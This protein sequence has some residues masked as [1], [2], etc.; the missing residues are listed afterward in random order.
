MDPSIIQPRMPEEA[1]VPGV[2]ASLGDLIRLQYKASGFSFLP[3]Q[4]VH[5]ILAGRRASR[6]RGR[7][8]DFEELRR[9]LPGDDIRSIDWKVTARTQK[10]YTRVF[11]EERDRPALLLVDQRIAMFYGTVRSLK[12]YTAAELAAISA[13][14]VQSMD[15]RVGALVFND[16]EIAEFRPHRSRATILRI[17]QTVVRMNRDLHADSPVKSNP[18]MLNRV[19]EGALRLAKHDFLVTVI[20]DFDGVDDDT[21][22]LVLRLSQHND[23]LLLLVH[24][25]SATTL[26]ERGRIVVSD[27]DLQVEVDLGASKEHKAL[28]A[29]SN[30]RLQRVL[31]WQRELG[32]PVLPIH[33]GADVPE[34]IRH[35]LGHTHRTRRG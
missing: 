18:G 25:P 13:W 14:R 15:D 35:L 21:R 20:S 2:Y 6:V 30:A 27:G 26:P 12:S 33:T 11:T 5:S 32:V 16:S 23:V 9:Y 3:R 29:F 24:D 4:P 10:P 17:L 28:L 34:Q 19:L 1:G 8:F 7:G 22:G 31:A